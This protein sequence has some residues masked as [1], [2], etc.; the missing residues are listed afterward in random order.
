[1]SGD[2]RSPPMLL[3]AVVYEAEPWLLNVKNVELG[4]AIHVSINV[5]NILYSAH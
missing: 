2:S 4:P 5:T 3:T 1:M